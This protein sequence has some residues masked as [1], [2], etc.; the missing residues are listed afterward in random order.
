M[1][2]VNYSKSR[3]NDVLGENKKSLV[4]AILEDMISLLKKYPEIEI[5][6]LTKKENINLL[7]DKL[8]VNFIF[9]DENDL[10]G[11]LEKGVSSLKEKYESILILPLDLPFIN[12]IDIESILSISKEKYGAIS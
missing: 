4:I 3:L 7:P 9:E 11:A 5:Y 12:E 2:Y 6:L 1:K 10:N 8:Q